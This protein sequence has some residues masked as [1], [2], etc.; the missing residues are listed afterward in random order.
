VKEC[1]PEDAC[2]LAASCEAATGLCVQQNKPNETPCDLDQL[3]LVDRRCTDG[4]CSGGAPRRCPPPNPCVE[5]AGCDPGLGCVFVAKEDDTLCSDDDACTFGDRCASGECVATG[6]VSCD[7][8]EPCRPVGVCDRRTGACSYPILPDGT[9]C[10]DGN[11]CTTG[12]RCDGGSCLG[13]RASPLHEPCSEGVCFTDVTR[14]VG[15]TLTTTSPAPLLI[16]GGAAFLDYD[17]DGAIDLLVTGENDGPEMYRNIGRGR[18]SRA[19]VGLPRLVWPEQIMGF[20]VGDYDNDG[21]PDLYLIAF[22]MSRLLENDAGTFRDATE[23]SGVLNGGW[24]TGAAFADFDRDGWLDLYLGNYIERSAPSGLSHVGQPNK[25]YRNLGNGSFENVTGRLGVAGAGTTLSVLWSD[26]DRDRDLDLFVC[27]DFG[28]FV[29]PNRLYENDGAG[30]FSE[31]SANLSA[32]LAIFCM[33]SVQGD[34]DRDGD[35]DYYFTNLGRNVL[36]AN[37][38]LG[39]TDLTSQAGIGLE[40]DRCL[41]QLYTTSWSAGFQD[42]N[43]DGWLD[44]YVS[45]GFIPA[46]Q[47]IANAEESED[48]LFLSQGASLRF[49]DVSESAGVANP[50]IGRGAAF[51]DYDLD[52]D[53]DILQLDLTGRPLLLRNDS[54]ASGGWLEVEAEGRLSSRDPIGARIEVDLSNVTLVR[55]LNPSYGYLSSSDPAV[56]FGLGSASEARTLFVRWPSRI[57]QTLVHVPA[58]MRISIVEPVATVSS[59]TTSA[60]ASAGEELDVRVALQSHVQVDLQI[61]LAYELRMASGQV[62]TGTPATVTVSAGSRTDVSRSIRAPQGSSGPGEIIVT[63]SDTAGGVDQRA[64]AVIIQP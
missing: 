3:C 36:L 56:H 58:M 21:D 29:E 25:L 59:A 23:A 49:R 5:S 19:S 38:P 50:G 52:G 37:E 60:I 26:F 22:G 39:F 43:R 32:D 51:A 24:G 10:E 4:I 30:F 8:V 33:G 9:S 27:N 54:P 44:L 46:L 55:E 16:G 40:R 20:A 18:F 11:L 45:N 1:A 42:F 12:D 57:E 34:Y 48:T 17:S 64:L 15:I 63:A 6:S 28:A 31:V 7:L 14:A 13:T 2:R 35:L 53:V 61:E 47:S 62:S 41:P